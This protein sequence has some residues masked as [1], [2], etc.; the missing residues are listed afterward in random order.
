ML[1]AETEVAK[2]GFIVLKTRVH[3][4]SPHWTNENGEMLPFV[5]EEA[6]I[7]VYPAASG[8][9]KIDFSINLLA[10]HEGI[11]IGGSE[12][13]KGYGGFSPRFVLPEDVS[14]RGISGPV[15][16]QNEAV[17]AG[18]VIDIT[19]TFGGNHLSGISIIQYPSNPGFPQQWIL[20]NKSSM[21]NPVYPGRNPVKLSTTRQT[22]LRYRLLLHGPDNLD[23]ESLAGE[24]TASN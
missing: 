4:K 6:S 19:G 5:E 17:S 21:Q 2:K 3:W 18:P 23:L 22:T 12:D 8:S 14:F 15:I 20:R 16:P 13:E 24:Y 9:R 1:S 11:S 7:T 10:L